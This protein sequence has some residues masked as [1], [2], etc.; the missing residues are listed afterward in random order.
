MTRFL[1]Q[2]A[3]A[4]RDALRRL[5]ASPLNTILSLIVIG[6]ALALPS[7]GRVVLDNL[8]DLTDS[9]SG[10]QQISIFMVAEAGKKDVADIESRLRDTKAGNWRFVSREEALKRLQA[11]EGMAEIIASLPRNPLPDAFIVE[12]TDTRP[13]S[14]ET[15]ALSA[16]ETSRPVAAMI[17]AR[18]GNAYAALYQAGEALIE[19]CATEIMEFAAKLPQD[20]LFVGDVKTKEKTFPRAGFVAFAAQQHL[21]RA[22]QEAD[23][24]YLRPSQAERTK[25]QS[26]KGA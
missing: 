11:S 22:V 13:D 7:A 23:P 25:Q 9:A 10:V 15:L 18:N 6:T 2:H 8:R 1:H 12:P 17:D 3:T 14:L 20:V 5:A 26:V 16:G 4:W 24:I 21:S 19:P